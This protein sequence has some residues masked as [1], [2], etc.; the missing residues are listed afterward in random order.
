MTSPSFHAAPKDLALGVAP[1]GIAGLRELI[2]PMFIHLL[3]GRFLELN[4]PYEN[5]QASYICTYHAIPR[6]MQDFTTF[7]QAC[8][9]LTV[10]P[11]A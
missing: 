4:L 1:G 8:I 3:V 5:Y 10:R 11:A 6:L 7:K 2:K 9:P